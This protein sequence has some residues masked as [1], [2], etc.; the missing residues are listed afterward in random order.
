MGWRKAWA[1]MRQKV[2]RDTWKKKKHNKRWSKR[3]LH[4]NLGEGEGRAPRGKVG[5]KKYWN[6]EK[7]NNPNLDAKVEKLGQARVAQS[8]TEGEVS[9]GPWAGKEEEE[10]DIYVGCKIF[11]IDFFG[12]YS[13]KV[14]REREKGTM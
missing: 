11:V 13:Y 5:S 12:S 1:L 9:W 10:E 3:E 6:G 7:L 14:E 8:Q 2:V 4:W